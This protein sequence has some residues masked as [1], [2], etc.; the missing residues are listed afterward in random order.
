MSWSPPVR[1]LDS[2]SL[3]GSY[4]VGLDH[5]IDPRRLRISLPARLVRVGEGDPQPRVPHE[6]PGCKVL[7]A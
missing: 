7:G 1:A 2:P 6:P 3:N 4:P 5:V